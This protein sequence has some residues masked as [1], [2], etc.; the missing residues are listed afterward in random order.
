MLSCSSLEGS[1]NLMP[2]VIID[3][4]HH[5]LH[6]CRGGLLRLRVDREPKEHDIPCSLPTF[7]HGFRD[8]AVVLLPSKL[9]SRSLPGD[10]GNG[11]AMA[12]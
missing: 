7:H 5:L 1:I 12:E 6:G 10:L 11:F 3:L 4:Q 8:L 2:P 9:R